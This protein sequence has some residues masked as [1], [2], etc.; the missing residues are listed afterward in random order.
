LKEPPTQPA[1]IKNDPL[2]SVVSAK[3]TQRVLFEN[4]Y[5]RVIE[6]R[7]PAGAA[8]S[9]HR[10]GASVLVPLS[11][12]DLE[13]TEQGGRPSSRK[14]MFGEAG[15]REPVVHSVKNVGLTELRNIRVEVK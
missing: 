10:H 4:T 9:L 7:V 3:A 5:V 8:E 15:W 13:I 14:V 11:D 1:S 12:A 2:D 6:E